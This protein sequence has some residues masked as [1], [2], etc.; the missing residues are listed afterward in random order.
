MRL[1]KPW[2][3]MTLLS[4]PPSEVK[5]Q[6]AGEMA[7][8]HRLQEAAAERGIALHSLEVIDEQISLFNDMAE[9]DQVA[10]LDATISQSDQVEL[11][12]EKMRSAYLDQDPARIFELMRAQQTGYDPALVETFTARFLNARN[13][14]MVERMQ[15]QLGEGGAFIAVG[16]LHLPGERGILQQLADQ[17]FRLTRLY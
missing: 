5:R 15:P 2:A 17:G 11:M 12:F 3:I 8:D 6:A 14:R 13:D 7:L 16:A 10:M 1:F 4:L 9:D